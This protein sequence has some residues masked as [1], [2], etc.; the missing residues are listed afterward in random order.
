[1]DNDTLDGIFWKA[2]IHSNFHKAF[3]TMPTFL[4]NANTYIFIVKMDFYPVAMC[5][6]LVCLW[7]RG[8]IC[9]AS[10]ARSE[11]QQRHKAGGFHQ[12]ALMQRLFDS[13]LC[14]LGTHWSTCMHTHQTYFYGWQDTKGFRYPLIIS[15]WFRHKPISGQERHKW[16]PSLSVGRFNFLDAFY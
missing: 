13:L 11:K 15:Y 5:C 8:I 10:L 7:I 1:M 3:I 16:K 4:H 2:N 6:S 9:V 14:P 12:A